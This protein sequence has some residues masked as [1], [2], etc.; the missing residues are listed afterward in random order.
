LPDTDA[1]PTTCP[2]ESHDA[3]AFAD[4]PNTLNVTVPP[5]ED[6]PDN[7]ADTAEAAIALPAL[8][9]DGALTDNDVADGVAPTTVSGIPSPHAECD[10]PLPPSPL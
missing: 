7:T 5:G 6:P 10:P 2:P 9:D 1:V 3:G 8:P 4:G